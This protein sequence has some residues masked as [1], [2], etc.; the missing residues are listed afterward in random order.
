MAILDQ[1]NTTTATGANAL[2]YSTSYLKFGQQF[3]PS[4]SGNIAEVHLNLYKSGS[5][6]GNVWAELWSDNGSN[7]PNAQLGTNSDTVST[8]SITG[9][10]VGTSQE[11]TFTFTNGPA[12]TSGTK[13]WIVFNGDYSI[14]TTNWIAITF[15]DGTD[16]YASGVIAIYAG[17]SWSAG[18]A[19]TDYN[20]KEYY[21]L[22][23]TSGYFVH[24][25][26]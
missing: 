20:F 8:A 13:Y 9:S 26:I 10:D 7:L 21:S 12:M 15:T 24:I 16:R 4:V 2:R 18:A 17:S 19:N 6:S 14:N 23:E 3:I 22:P 25:S 1:Q 5:P 11:I